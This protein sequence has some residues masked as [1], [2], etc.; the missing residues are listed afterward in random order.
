MGQE[1][2][3]QGSRDIASSIVPK[4]ESCGKA[5]KKWSSTN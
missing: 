2:S 5:L 4:I 3:K 1:W